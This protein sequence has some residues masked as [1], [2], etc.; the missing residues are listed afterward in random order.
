MLADTIVLVEKIR[1]FLLNIKK[2][3]E[4]DNWK[5][6]CCFGGNVGKY[7]SFVWLDATKLPC[8]AQS[9]DAAAQW[10]TETNKIYSLCLIFAKSLKFLSASN[11]F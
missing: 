5:S 9:A 10:R 1:Q 4:T 11:S 7:M 6:G 8:G 3:V 2:N